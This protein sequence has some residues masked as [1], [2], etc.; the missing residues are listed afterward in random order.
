MLRLIAGGYAEAGAKGLVELEFRNGALAVSATLAN[1]A[2]VSAGLALPGSSRWWLVE[3]R[4][5]QLV[6][7]DGAE[8]WRREAVLPSGGEGP[9][10]LAL[11]PDGRLLAVANYDSGTV[12]LLPLAPDGSPA[13]PLA[14]HQNHG[15]GPSRERQE[16][17]HAHWVGFGADR[18][19]YAVDLGA[20]RI[21]AFADPARGG[22]EAPA[23]VF[24]APPGSGPRQLAFHPALPLA[25]LVSE[26]ASTLTVLERDEAGLL[27]ARQ[28]IS[29]LPPGTAGE[30]LG[31]AIALS[32]DGGRLWVSNRGHDSVAAFAIDDGKARLVGHAPSG[33]SSPRFLLQ[34]EDCLFVAH[35]KSG[36][37]T[38]LAL[39]RDGT[40]HLSDARADVR[41]A[42]FLA[43]LPG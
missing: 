37:V 30:S 29:T 19:L 25:F 32:A 5:G 16:G 35:E 38:V 21:L 17:P 14:R 41:G 11:S 22:L 15:S 34:H 20:D 23:T 12:A 24:S 18:R 7:L 26:L 39:D 42:A 28:T 33:G 6:L 8:G 4:A 2:N 43:L 40:P 27:H 10:Y 31:G 3:E 36:G 1:V 13:G 9:C